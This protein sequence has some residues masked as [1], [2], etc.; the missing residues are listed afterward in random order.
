MGRY[1]GGNYHKN[2]GDDY[3]PCGS[4]DDLEPEPLRDGFSVDIVSVVVDDIFVD[5]IEKLRAGV[6]GIFHKISRTCDRNGRR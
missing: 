2:N 3:G 4:R 1:T 5:M 6:N